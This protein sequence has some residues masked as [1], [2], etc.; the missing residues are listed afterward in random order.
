MSFAAFVSFV[1]SLSADFSFVSAL[2]AGVSEVR[3]GLAV[4]AAG[5]AAGLLAGFEFDFA[6]VFVGLEALDGDLVLVARGDAGRSLFVRR[7]VVEFVRLAAVPLVLRLAAV[8]LPV[9]DARLVFEPDVSRSK[10][11]LFDFGGIY[12]KKVSNRIDNVSGRDFALA[13][14]SPRAI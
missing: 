6:A 10:T 14:V 4:F 13:P 12:K 3:R 11:P 9:R 1:S 2:R 7:A 5:F 8:P